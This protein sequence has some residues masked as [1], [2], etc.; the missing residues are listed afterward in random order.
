MTILYEID[1]SLYVNVTNACPCDCVFCVRQDHESVGGCASLW[2][3][4]EPTLEEIISEFEKQDLNCFDQIVFCGYGEPLVKLDNVLA[5]CKWIKARSQTPIRIN[6]N[7]LADL[8]HKKETAPLLEGLVDAISISLNAPDAKSYVDIA[9]P[10]F[11]EESF[12]H[13]VH[14]AKMCNKVIPKVTFS[15]VDVITKEQLEA[16]QQLADTMEIPLRVREMIE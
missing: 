14:F 4:H 9:K 5:L 11:G 13:L 6:T 16:C 15:V 7:G 2:L 3:E 10:C 1:Q 8:I 12:S